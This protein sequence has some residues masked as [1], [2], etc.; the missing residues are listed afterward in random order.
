MEVGSRR[1]RV[2]QNSCMRFYMHNFRDVPSECFHAIRLDSDD[3]CQPIQMTDANRCEWCAL[4]CILV[5]ACAPTV[6]RVHRA[7]WAEWASAQICQTGSMNRMAQQSPMAQRARLGPSWANG[8]AWVQHETMGTMGL[9][10]RQAWAHT[11][12]ARTIAQHDKADMSY[13]SIWRKPKNQRERMCVISIHICWHESSPRAAA[14]SHKS[15]AH[16]QTVFLQGWQLW[17]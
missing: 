7:H 9:G 10:P 5:R 6:H 3:R 11:Q 4:Y 17:T 13:T 1:T 14:G 16:L 8:P 2:Q 12:I 15:L